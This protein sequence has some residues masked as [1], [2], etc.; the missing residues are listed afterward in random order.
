MTYLAFYLG[1]LCMKFLFCTSDFSLQNWIKENAGGVSS[2]V[3]GF[4]LQ[5]L[6]NDLG[7]AQY[8]KK[9]ECSVDIPGKGGNGWASGK[10]LQYFFA[11]VFV[12]YSC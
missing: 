3:Q 7:I 11:M 5:K 2:Q 12:D 8:L 4:V 9:D 1:S 6:M 10:L